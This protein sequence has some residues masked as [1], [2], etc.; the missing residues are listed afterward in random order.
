[1]RFRTAAG[2]LS[3]AKVGIL[4]E[5]LFAYHRAIDL[6]LELPEP[7][8]AFDL[9]EQT[10]ARALL[11]LMQEG[12]ADLSGHLSQDEQQK[13]RDLQ[14]K[15]SLL[16]RQLVAEA[17]R[18]A[19]EG[20]RL[21]EIKSQLAAA[22]RELDSFTDALQAKYGGL[23]ELRAASTLSLSG[24]GKLLPPDTALLEYVTL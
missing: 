23:K 3:Q 20:K 24:L 15:L 4:E 18:Q 8:A 16:H 14:A 5:N 2:S 12:K 11:D 19:P 7:R 21:D 22:E 10:K 9:A 13:E 17:A 1:E 6:L